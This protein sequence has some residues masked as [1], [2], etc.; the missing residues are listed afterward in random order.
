[1]PRTWLCLELRVSILR[2][3]PALS[4]S[5]GG[6]SPRLIHHPEAVSLRQT[7]SES[8]PIFPF[9]KNLAVGLGVSAGQTTAL[10]P[11]PA[12]S[13]DRVAK[14]PVLTPRGQVSALLR[15]ASSL[16]GPGDPAVSLGASW[17]PPR[18]AS[19]HSQ[20]PPASGPL[21]STC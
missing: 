4:L 15:G 17:S 1:M 5:C 2:V 13:T 8:P 21:L 6:S 10:G 16:H 20:H 9:E 7:N 14:L 11:A 19:T 18:Q 12:V 3:Y